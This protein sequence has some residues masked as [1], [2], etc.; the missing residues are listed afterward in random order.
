VV[1]REAREDGS[2]DVEVPRFEEG[3]R[4][5]NKIWQVTRGVVLPQAG[6]ASPP[7]GPSPFLLDRWMT[8]RLAG[9]IDAV[10][11][12]LEAYSIGDACSAFYHL[13]WD[14]FCSWYV[15]MIKPRLWEG[16]DH[17]RTT[18]LETLTAL[19][20]LMHPVMP[21]ITEAL[22]QE[23]ASLRRSCGLEDLGDR[24]ITAPW[25]DPSHLPRDPD[26][27]RTVEAVRSAAAA[28]NNIRGENP[29]IKE[30][31]KLPRVMLCAPGDLAPGIDEMRE[32]FLRFVNASE[33]D[34]GAD[35]AKPEACAAAVA[36]DVDVWVPLEGLVDAKAERARLEKQI[37][38]AG[39][40]LEAVERKLA[41]EKFLARA[42]EHIV[43]KERGKR[44]ELV[45]AIEK[46]RASLDALSLS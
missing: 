8:T 45:Q 34:A 23:V 20:R 38:T 12:H 3:R 25:P 19:L 43:A 16:D 37:A 7:T 40:K 29:S 2:W 18:M 41:N 30:N 31:Q 44:D 33:L 11:G 26:A 32:G 39:K 35:L 46:L 21:F 4:F 9:G 14:D 13:F 36:G 1:R 15:E 42:P 5:C 6:G 27:V 28:V 24:I 10:T 17:A 22:W